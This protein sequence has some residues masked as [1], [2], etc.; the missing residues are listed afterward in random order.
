LVGHSFRHTV[1]NAEAPVVRIADDGI[2]GDDR[3]AVVGQR[4]TLIGPD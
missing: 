2:V 3:T 4:D 1:D